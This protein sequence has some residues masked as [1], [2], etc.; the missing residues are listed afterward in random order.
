MEINTLAGA[1]LG[2]EYI[3]QILFLV[4]PT[5]EIRRMGWTVSCKFNGVSGEKES[6]HKCDDWRTCGKLSKNGS[7][8]SGC[9][10]WIYKNT[11]IIECEL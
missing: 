9:F 7:M 6:L 1:D 2:I 10:V 4:I 8:N 3:C 5:K 11:K